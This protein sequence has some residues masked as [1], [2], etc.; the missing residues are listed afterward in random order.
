[1]QRQTFLQPMETREF[2]WSTR[3]ICVWFLS[4][5]ACII[6][7]L[8][9]ALPIILYI[10]CLFLITVKRES[11][12][13]L[14]GFMV[15]TVHPVLSLLIGVLMKTLGDFFFDNSCEVE[16]TRLAKVYL[17]LGRMFTYSINLHFT[18]VSGTIYYLFQEWCLMKQ[19]SN[20]DYTNSA[21]D[22]CTCQKLKTL[23]AC[24]N[25]DDDFQ[26]K[27][28]KYSIPTFLS[29]FFIA[30]LICHFVQACLTILPPPIRLL[31]YMLGSIKVHVSKLRKTGNEMELHPL[32]ERIIKSLTLQSRIKT[33]M[34]KVLKMLASLLGLGI[35]ISLLCTPIVLRMFF[36]NLNATTC[37]TENYKPCLI[38]F[39]FNQT[40]HYSCINASMTDIPYGAKWC[41]TS[42]DKDDIGTYK[43]VGLCQDSC[44]GSKPIFHNI[45]N[46]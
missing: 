44:P 28:I 34:C 42:I 18:F 27:F 24:T 29:I 10:A 11:D 2:E 46:N 3:G 39:E 23:A 20:L 38:P 4:K 13:I 7:L 37:T 19:S 25:S 12:I 5:L 21:F 33:T 1:M 8:T 36:K 26:Q 16:S 22:Q 17:I 35:V 32:E 40:T 43:T 9:S 14:A 45:T 6:Y 31:D 15:V 30:S 41:P